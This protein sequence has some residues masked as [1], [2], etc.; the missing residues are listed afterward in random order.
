MDS[1]LFKIQFG[2]SL[3]TLVHLKEHYCNDKGDFNKFFRVCLLEICS[4][5]ILAIREHIFTYIS[6][7]PLDLM[8]LILALILAT[9]LAYQY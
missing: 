6:T 8:A 3:L 5:K 9:H 1:I 2:R 4:P 7:I